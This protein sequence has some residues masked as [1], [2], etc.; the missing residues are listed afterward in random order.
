MMPRSFNQLRSLA[1]WAS[2]TAVALSAALVAGAA[3][4]PTYVGADDQND[5]FPSLR[6]GETMTGI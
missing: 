2:F 4:L 6:P 1:K 3:F 5:A